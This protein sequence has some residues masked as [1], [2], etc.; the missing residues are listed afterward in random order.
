MDTLFNVLRILGIPNWASRRCAAAHSSDALDVAALR[1]LLEEVAK[2]TDP[3][4]LRVRREDAQNALHAAELAGG[5]GHDAHMRS[6]PQLGGN[7]AESRTLSERYRRRAL[8]LLGLG[9]EW[10]ESAQSAAS[11]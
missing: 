7:A 3:S 1:V 4:L 9:A 11:L 2:L 8:D 10:K 6:T 5:C